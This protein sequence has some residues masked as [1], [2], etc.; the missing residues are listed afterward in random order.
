MYDVAKRCLPDL[1]EEEVLGMSAA[2]IGALI[3]VAQSSIE[4][5]EAAIPKQKTL[6][7]KGNRLAST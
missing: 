3:G 2:Q 6:A 5:V 7:R 4:E 1:S